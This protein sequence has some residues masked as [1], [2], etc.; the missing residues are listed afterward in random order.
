MILACQ[1]LLGQITKV[2]GLRRPPFLCWEKFP[3]NPVFFFW[4]LPL[5]SFGPFEDCD[6]TVLFA[7]TGA[8]YAIWIKKVKNAIFSKPS[9]L[10]IF[11]LLWDECTHQGQPKTIESTVG[12]FRPS[13]VGF[14]T[15]VLPMVNSSD[16]LNLTSSQVRLVRFG[17]K[18]SGRTF[19]AQFLWIISKILRMTKDYD[20][21]RT[22]KI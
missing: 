17:N 3:N 8:L 18:S 6:D 9:N 15:H 22:K 20:D 21:E 19:S 16:D 4:C 11:P 10:P 12:L 1:K 7:P 5:G 14:L 13:W 2:L